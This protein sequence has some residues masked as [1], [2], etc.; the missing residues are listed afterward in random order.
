MNA[1][2]FDEEEEVFLD[3]SSNLLAI[4]FKDKRNHTCYKRRENISGED[5]LSCS[6]I[7]LSL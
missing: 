7:G 2:E 5:M 3:F 4:G 1:E 6:C